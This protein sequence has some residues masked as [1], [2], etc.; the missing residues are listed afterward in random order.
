MYDFYGGYGGMYGGVGSMLVQT[1]PG[2]PLVAAVPV[3]VPMQPV[4]WYRSPSGE[5]QYYYTMGYPSLAADG[6]SASNG[7]HEPSSRRNSVESFQS[8]QVSGR[9]ARRHRTAP[10]L[11]PPAH[12]LRK[13]SLHCLGFL[14]ASSGQE[15]HSE[16]SLPSST[17]SSTVSSTVHSENGGS[18]CS[19]GPSSQGPAS[20]QGDAPAAPALKASLGASCDDHK[21]AGAVTT[22][23]AYLYPCAYPPYGMAPPVYA[24]GK[25]PLTSS[26]LN[27]H[28]YFFFIS[29]SI[30]N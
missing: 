25:P 26:S 3:P 23:G 8:H 22:P 14:Q 5:V 21:M 20:P 7:S 27:S 29:N 19:T 13:R 9:P 15:A 24:A 18:P 6:S 10:S 17:A 16:T 2:G 28:I 1:Y 30:R 11:G 4:D 12:T